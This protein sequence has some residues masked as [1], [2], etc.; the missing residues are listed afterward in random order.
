MR[1]P[2]TAPRRR[3]RVCGRCGRRAGRTAACVSSATALAHDDEPQRDGL[4]DADL[5]AVGD[6]EVPEHRR[7]GRDRG[8]TDDAQ[9]VAPV[10]AHQDR[11]RHAGDLAR[12]LRL[13]ELRRLVQGPADEVGD[14]D[15]ER[16]QPERDPPPPA[17]LHVVGQRHDRDEHEGREDLPALGAREGPRR[18]EGP[19]V[20]GGVLE[21]QRR[22][23]GLLPR[24]GQPL[25]DPAGDEQNRCEPADPV[26]RGQA[27]D[28][29]RR[30]TP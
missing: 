30:H 7:D 15:D 20:V 5:L 29:E 1:A 14:E 9:D 13:L 16:A 26:V 23:P 4:V 22:R 19:P 24:R 3:T 12:R 2:R 27:A 28:D 25:Q 10:L 8:A 6:G 17:E 18:E 11:Q 21:R